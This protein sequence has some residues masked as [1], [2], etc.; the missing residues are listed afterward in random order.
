MKREQ[1][2][3]VVEDLTQRLKAAETLLVADYRGL[4]MPQIDQLR[5]RLLESGA[6]FTVVKN[7]LTRRAAE[8]AGADA[9]LALL[10]GPSAIAFL[11]ADGDMVAAAKALADAARETNVL[12][13]RGG[14]MQGRSLT[15][16]EVQSLATLPPA[17][18]LRGQVLGAIVAPLTALAGLLNAPLQNLVGLI[19]A[20][21]DQLGGEAAAEPPPGEAPEAV[22][23][24][25][26]A[27]P[28]GDATAS[29]GQEV[30]EPNAEES[31]EEE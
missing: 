28:V 7:T 19:D 1:K 6:R 13:I 27:T 21:I 23:E 11:E 18:V 10:D 16:A 22:D 29:T 24:V 4:T 12:E 20:R 9:L 14:I 26:E 25:A 5:T 2:E 8:A 31:S 30:E 17:D 15:A 3:Q